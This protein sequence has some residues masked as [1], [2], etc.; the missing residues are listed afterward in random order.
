[1]RGSAHEYIADIFRELVRLDRAD[2]HAQEL[3]A[4]SAAIALRDIHELTRDA[5]ELERQWH[6]QELLDPQTA[7][8]TLHA[9]DAEL[10]R[11]VPQ[12]ANLRTRQDE[13]ARTMR[14]LLD[15]PEDS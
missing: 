8:Q 6:V 10:S 3:L 2:V 14:G 13:V 7:A 15:R 11:V 4:D 9:F 1:V 12:L 5:R